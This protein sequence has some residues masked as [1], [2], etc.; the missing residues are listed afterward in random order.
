[1]VIKSTSID[2]DRLDVS[3]IAPALLERAR[4]TWA[5]RART[6]HRSIEIMTRFLVE[7]QGAGEPI[8]VY[9]GTLELIEDEIRHTALC[10]SMCRA[11]GASV[12][13]DR[14]TAEVTPGLQRAP[15]NERA[16]ATAIAML[17]VNETLSV[18]YIRDLA[19]RCENPVVGAVLR[20]TVEDEDEHEAF[21]WTYVATALDRFPK[22]THPEWRAFTHR[23][24]QPHLDRAGKALAAIAPEDR[25]LARFPDSEII[26]LGLTSPQ[27]QAIVCLT[28]FQRDLEPRLSKLG[29]W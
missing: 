14:P 19:A 10:R 16:L 12:P 18:G 20:A 8:E 28:T 2:F 27:R 11:L 23:V 21:G 6:E 29:L 25:A 22:T 5:D 24:V 9:A 15:M 7:L 17:A 13:A 26:D 3:T 1:M 4:A